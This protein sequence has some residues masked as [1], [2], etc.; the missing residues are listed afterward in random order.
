M[1]TRQRK[2][3]FHIIL[4]KPSKYDDDGYVIRW[5]RGVIT[6][7]S[8]ACLYAL[9]KGVCA[10]GI[11]GDDVEPVIYCLDE[12]VQKIRVKQLSRN[13]LSAGDKGIACMVGVQT[14]QF[15]R[16]LDLSLEFKARGI[17]SMIGGFHVSG[18]LE[19]LPDYPPEI[20]E[21]MDAGI[22]LVGGEVE[23]KWGDLLEDAY[24][25]Q[26]KN[27]YNFINDKP[28]LTGVPGPELARDTAL[29]FLNRQTSFDA[30]RGCPFHCS[31]CTIINIQGNFMRGRNADDIEKLV[32]H[33]FAHGGKHIFITDDNFARHKEWEIIADRLIDL[34]ENQGIRC[35]LM[36]QTDTVAHKIPRFIEK[37]TRAGVRRVFIGMESVNPENLRATGKF[38]NQIKEYRRMLQ[39]WRDHGALTYAGYIIGFPGDT[40]ESIMRDVEFLKNEIPLDLAEFFI[41]TPLP[42]SK[43]HQKY[44]LEKVPLEPDTNRYD[45]MH[46]CMQHPKMTKQEWLNAYRDAWKSF[47]SFEHMQTLL[48][49]RK[50][51]RR[52]LLFSSLVW[53]YVSLFLSD[54]HPLL[55]GFFRM[56]E[57]KNRRRGMP[58]EAFISFYL[59][60]VWEHVIYTGSLLKA[61]W[62]IWQLLRRANRPENADYTDSAITPQVSGWPFGYETLLPKP[63]VCTTR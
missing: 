38:H 30:G 11:L 44:Y 31:F 7:N 24:K 18:C 41:L 27:I 6:S 53:F 47:Y 21:A 63:A 60:R 43:D 10:Q 57:R 56:K 37:M 35:S 14:N 36:I 48:L 46:V 9:T 19:M 52:R 16:A 4:I 34:K 55:G 17:P 15:A 29:C 1:K 49:R 28:C 40:Y 2:K 26:L 3:K 12:T 5:L 8:L 23:G 20:R 62:D 51:P 45:T 32:R 58:H 59:K 42:G 25:G 22:T 39:S 13:I 33:N 50:G 61:L 54:T